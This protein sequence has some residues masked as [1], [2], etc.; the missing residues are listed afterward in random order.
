MRT[1]VLVA[2]ALASLSC[3]GS[4]PADSRYPP[5][6]E[7]CDVKLFHGSPTVPTDNLGTVMARC[8]TDVSEGACI[9]QLQD[10]ACKLG[11]DVVWGVP[12]QATLDGGKNLWVARAAHTKSSAAAPAGSAP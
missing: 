4:K 5:R 3:G 10:E 8:S 7:G 12:D 11:G 1:L 6:P 9:R 2:I